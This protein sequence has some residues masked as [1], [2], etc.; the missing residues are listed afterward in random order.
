M[1][2]TALLVI[3]VVEFVAAL[4]VLMSLGSGYELSSNEERDPRSPATRRLRMTQ[5]S[6][7]SHRKRSSKR[8]TRSRYERY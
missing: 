6:R 1:M 8:R 5:L 2:Q 4:G 3:F 7:H